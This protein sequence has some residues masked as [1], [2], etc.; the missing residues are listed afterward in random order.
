MRN[1]LIIGLSGRD[2]VTLEPLLSF[3]VKY[4]TH[5]NYSSILI[6]V[7]NVVF[8]LYAG[9]VGKSILV[10]ELFVKM[11]ERLREE[12]DVQKQFFELMGSLDSL[13]AAQT[14]GVVGGNQDE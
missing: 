14:R 13:M 5:P 10:D 9:V 3:L 6:T 12:I 1:G 11:R 4:I 7:C 8:D 2:E